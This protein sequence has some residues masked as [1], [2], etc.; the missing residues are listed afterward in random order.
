MSERK[1]D[2]NLRELTSDFQNSIAYRES[3]RTKSKI[4]LKRDQG[5]WPV[6]IIETGAIPEYSY[7]V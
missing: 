2:Q 7:M 5:A 3:F 6:R 4:I 1:K